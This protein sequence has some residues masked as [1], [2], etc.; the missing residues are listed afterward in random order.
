M[1]NRESVRFHQNNR[2]KQQDNMN[3]ELDLVTRPPLRYHGGKF[4]LAPWIIEHLPA[5][6]NYVEVFGGAAGVLLRKPRSRVEVY[7]DLD[8]QVFG[9]FKCLRDPEQLSRLITALELTPFA[10]EE[11]DLSYEFTTDPVEAAR[12][13]CFRTYSGHGTCSMAPNDSNGFR[14]CDIRAGKSYANEWSG[15]PSAIA[16]A[17]RRMLGVTIENMDFKKLLPKFDALETCYYVDPPYP[18]STR[19]GGGKGYV[20]EMCDEDHRQL[21]WMLKNLKAKVLISG[22]RCRL[23][24][25]LYKGWTQDEKK[26]NANGQ[27]GAVSRIEILWM[28][29]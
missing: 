12:R 4:R 10:R 17:A 20:H 26:T 9:F 22:Y 18:H 8:S 28:N 25:E 27:S 15:V 29:F 2:L 7:N 23:Y 16:V 19:N 1:T 21:A 14:S 24:D 6:E 11:F 5:H 3:A 13:F